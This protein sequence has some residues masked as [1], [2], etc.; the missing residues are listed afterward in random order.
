MSSACETLELAKTDL[1]VKAQRVQSDPTLLS[2]TD[3]RSLCQAAKDVLQ[4]MLKV[5][6]PNSLPVKCAT[7][8]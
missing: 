7:F 4:A 1:F 6:S 8:S 2:S 3:R 5:C